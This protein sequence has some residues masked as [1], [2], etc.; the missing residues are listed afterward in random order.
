MGPGDTD[1]RSKVEVVG[2]TDDAK[3]LFTRI[4]AR[5]DEYEHAALGQKLF[6]QRV[7]L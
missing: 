5:D 6:V 1:E 4:G 2:P 7:Q 3:P